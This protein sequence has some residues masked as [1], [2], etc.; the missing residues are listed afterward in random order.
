MDLADYA[1]IAVALVALI[2]VF[3]SM[4]GATGNAIY[5]PAKALGNAVCTESGACD[6]GWQCCDKGSCHCAY[7]DDAR[8]YQAVMRDV[9]SSQCVTDEQGL[10]HCE[11]SSPAMGRPR[12]E[13]TEGI[14][15]R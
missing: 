9:G 13:T 2:G 8:L 11:P 14:F 10:L 6:A 15:V 1:V 4:S 12:D 5:F 3:Q 7:D